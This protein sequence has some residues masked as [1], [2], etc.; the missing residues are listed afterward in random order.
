MLLSETIF[1]KIFDLVFAFLPFFLP[2]FIF[3]SYIAIC[4]LHIEYKCFQDVHAAKNTSRMLEMLV[5]IRHYKQYLQQQTMFILIFSSF[6]CKA[7]FTVLPQ[8]FLL[9][10]TSNKTWEKIR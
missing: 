6:Y 7:D 9:N 8:I 2:D 5:A 1:N 3:Y 4:D 10:S